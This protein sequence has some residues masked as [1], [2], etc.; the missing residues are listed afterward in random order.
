MEKRLFKQLVLTLILLGIGFSFSY[1]F[2]LSSLPQPTCYD[3]KKNQKEEGIDCG[4]PCIPCYLKEENN[5][6]V[7][8][9]PIIFLRDDNKVDVMFKVKNVLKDWGV[10]NFSYKLIF[11]S[12]EGQQ[13][14]FLL[15]GFIWPQEIRIFTVDSLEVGFRPEKVDVEILKENIEWAKPLK[16]ID[17]SQE[18]PFIL[19]NLKMNFPKPLEQE[20]RNIYIFTKTL[21][22]GMEDPE[23]FNLQ[24]VLSLDPTI[25]PEGKITGFFG[26]ATE[27]AVMRFQRKYGIRVTG[28]V[29]P[30]TRSKLNE[31]YG[32]SYL[33]PFSYTFKNVLKKGMSGIEVINLQR[34]LM[35]DSTAH[36]KGLISGYFGEETE[37]ALKEFQKRYGLTPTGIVDKPTMEKLNEL[38]SKEEQYSPEFVEVSREPFEGT[39]EVVGDLFNRSIYSFK[40]GEIGVVLCDKDHNYLGFSKVAVKNIYF[41]EK[42]SFKIIFF[43][44]FDKEVNICEEIININILDKDNV[45]K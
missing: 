8:S 37:K 23:V 45:L 25:Y 21:K 29:G 24:K 31:L 34:A 17:L 4:G 33:E 19:M 36:P 15:N 13:K 2:Y 27:K 3:N 38:Y 40:N 28:E 16:G 1:Y 22:K 39:L 42:Q 10:K 5:L 44:K 35:I 32:P 14:D 7:A 6:I 18:K 12:K 11:T 43:Q 9:S 41:N 26:S 20:E 30:Q